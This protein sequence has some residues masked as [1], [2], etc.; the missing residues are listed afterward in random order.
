MIGGNVLAYAEDFN[1]FEGK[2]PIPEADPDELGTGA[3]HRLY[4][5]AEGWVFLSAPTEAQWLALAGAVDGES[6]ADDPRFATGVDRVANDAALARELGPRL[7]LRTAKEWE[8]VLLA[9]G[10]GCVEANEES[11][12]QFT[13]FDERLRAVGLVVPIEHPMFG[14]LWR[15]APP[16]ALSCTPG[17]ILPGCT[18]AQHS[19]AILAELGRSDDEIA[20]L[21]AHGVVKLAAPA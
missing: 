4:K 20:D 1:R 11:Q 2:V 16:A 15:Y 5:A 12:A 3:L 7:T 10:V 17:P 14:Q 18:F 21:A 6:L 8:D 9:A 19:A 13:S